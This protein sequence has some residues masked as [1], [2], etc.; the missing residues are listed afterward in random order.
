MMHAEVETTS[1][2]GE[3]IKTKLYKNGFHALKKVVQNEGIRGLYHGLSVNL[4]RGIS[5]ALLLVGYDEIK[6][7]FS[8]YV[9]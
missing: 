6:D 3:I 1:A 2:S 9:Y 8:K 4:V 7:L 5:G